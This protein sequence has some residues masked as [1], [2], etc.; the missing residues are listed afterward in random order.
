M[1]RMESGLVGDLRGTNIVA[2]TVA[3]LAVLGQHRL[4]FDLHL[5]GGVQQSRHDDHRRRR[6]RRA[7]A[8]RR[9]RRRRRR[10]RRPTVTYIRVRTT[11]SS[12]APASASA[13]AMI[14]KQRRAWAPAVV[15]TPAARHDRTRPGDDDAVAHPDG[16][17]EADGGLEGRARRD[18]QTVGHAP[19]PPTPAHGSRRPVRLRHGGRMGLGRRRIGVLAGS[20]GHGGGCR[21]TRCRASSP[22]PRPRPPA[23]I[24]RRPPPPL[25]PRRRPRRAGARRPARRARWWPRRTAPSPATRRRSPPQHPT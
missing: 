15:R 5:P 8:A 23:P 4:G 19:H 13:A 2:A 7:R 10:R 11:S 17:A 21:R 12:D 14:S 6:A 25:P 24:T 20:R 16:P 22:A 9:A 18:A 1:N 3:G